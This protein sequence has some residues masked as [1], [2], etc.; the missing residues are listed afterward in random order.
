MIGQHPLVADEVIRHH[1]G[2]VD[3][4]GIMAAW[5]NNKAQAFRDGI[6]LRPTV[7]ELLDAVDALGLPKS[8]CTS[9]SETQVDVKLFSAMLDE[10]FDLIVSLDDVTQAKPS[11]EPYL[12]AASRMGVPAKECIAFED[13]ESGAESAYK[14]GM[15]VVQV[16]DLGE[17]KGDYAHFVAKTLMDGARMSGL[18]P[19]FD[20]V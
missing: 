10:R 11:P 4:A 17:F 18:L 16:P 14:A 15:T 5:A 9:S 6:P 12:T 3:L 7:L 8:I 1:F 19:S 2:N 20:A 13:S